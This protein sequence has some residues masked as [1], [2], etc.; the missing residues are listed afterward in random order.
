MG[1]VPGDSKEGGWQA[2]ATSSGQGFP[3]PSTPRSQRAAAQRA[4]QQL[5]SGGGADGEGVSIKG[6]SHLSTEGSSDG[7][8]RRASDGDASATPLEEEP[9][10]RRR[11]R[12][13]QAEINK[14]Y[15]EEQQE[16][17]RAREQAVAEAQAQT[18]A[19]AHIATGNAGMGMSDSS[20]HL[21]PLGSYASM[22]FLLS[23]FQQA[24]LEGSFLTNPEPAPDVVHRLSIFGAIPPGMV[25]RWFDER[26]KKSHNEQ[27]T[28]MA[29][30]MYAHASTVAMSQF[31]RSF[32]E[33]QMTPQQFLQQQHHQNHHPSR[34]GHRSGESREERRARKEKRR[35]ERRERKEKAK[36]EGAGTPISST[37]TGDES[38]SGASSHSPSQMST[39]LLFGS[40]STP[41]I[42]ILSSQSAA[43][44]L[45]RNSALFTREST[46]G[47]SSSF[48]GGF[49]ITS[50][51]FVDF[52]EEDSMPFAI[53]PS[54]GDP[55]GSHS[56]AYSSF[57]APSPS[58][59]S[60]SVHDS[61]STPHGDFG[62]RSLDTPTRRR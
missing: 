22:D 30:P 57:L 17:D 2:S 24:I 35:K 9:P 38:V 56:H 5:R 29:A 8:K 25:E 23:P 14:E 46:G 45:A 6:E 49:A 21:P 44:Q 10:Y 7:R 31:N 4:T 34:G 3:A 26:R 60:S 42:G 33:Q 48:T 13:L 37:T 50:I 39:P 15:E 28:M 1:L 19:Q 27:V 47:H 43:Q 53:F 32:Q 62:S 12:Q 54:Y 58:E 52:P 16:V 51:P 41:S 18:Q 11:R 20:S 61:G 36:E 59:Y 55:H 40:G